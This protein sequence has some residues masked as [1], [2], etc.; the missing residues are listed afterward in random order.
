MVARVSLLEYVP[1]FLPGIIA[2]TLAQTPRFK[3]YLWPPFVLLLAGIYA[4]RPSTGT[5]WMLSLV[6][7]FAIPFF[8][9]IQTVW[10]RTASHRIATY[11][12]GIYLSHQFCIWFVA[13]P[14]SG[15][16]LWSRILV[17][18]TILV[19]IPV[20]LYHC[21]EKPMINVG[22]YL[23]EKWTARPMVAAAA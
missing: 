15:L 20:V 3:S 19:G 18:V 22:A 1:S 17:L 8:G 5:G 2:F 9:E 13:E 23:A 12:Y 10:L 14:L 21:I 16:P 6:L 7:G 11:S 4:A